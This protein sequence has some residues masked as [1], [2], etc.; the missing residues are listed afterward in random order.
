MLKLTITKNLLCAAATVVLLSACNSTAL[1]GENGKNTTIWQFNDQA[2]EDANLATV[3]YSQGDF[4]EAQRLVDR[5]LQSNPKLPQALIVSAMTA[6]QLGHYNRARQNYEDLILLNSDDMTLLGS[7]SGKPEKMSQ[8]AQKRLRNITIQQSKL[9][10]EDDNGAKVFNI[11]DAA[12]L[13]QSKSAL[14]K[15]IFL[16]QKHKPQ[17]EVPTTQEQIEAAEILFDDDEQNIIARFLTLKE[18]AEK[19]LI[20]QDEFLAARSSNIGGLLPLTNKAPAYGINR[21]VPSP[22]LIIERINVLKEATEANAITP[23]E[24]SAERDLII[25]TLLPPQPRQ[26]AKR[27]LPSK[28]I[29]TAAK[30]LR[31]LEVLHD[32]NLITSNEKEKEKSAIERYIG[33]NK[34]PQP[35]KNTAKQAANDLIQ[36][37]KEENSQKTD[38]DKSSVE[39]LVPMVSSPF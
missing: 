30:N 1:H 20:T 15:A 22:D 38:E 32:L 19:D 36:P 4:K 13:R 2:Q 23:K 37:I 17:K 34:T 14:A 35:A 24:F 8:I 12:A 33:I 3:A 31:K 27:Q 21:P 39:P 26:R 29:L 9:I 28:D 7:T 5:S 10:I 11:E 18:L 16:S 25:E 6:E